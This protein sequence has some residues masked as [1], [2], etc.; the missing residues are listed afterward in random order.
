MNETKFLYS[1]IF[2]SSE[3]GHT[4]MLGMETEMQGPA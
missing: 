4:G 2:V 3:K 1:G